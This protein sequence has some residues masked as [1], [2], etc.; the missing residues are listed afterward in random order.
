MESLRTVYAEYFANALGPG[1]TATLLDAA[2]AVAAGD[3]ERFSYICQTARAILLRTPAA[4]SRPADLALDN[5]AYLFDSE[6]GREAD[7]DLGGVAAP[8]AK[9]S[10]MYRCPECDSTN[11]EHTTVLK[12]SAD[13]GDSVSCYCNNCGYTFE[14]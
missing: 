8:V 10:V 13:E 6:L 4:A 9:A 11:V 2:Q 5:A 1:P 3:P 7:D 12:R 14:L